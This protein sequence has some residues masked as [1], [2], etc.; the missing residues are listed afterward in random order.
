MFSV[1]NSFEVKFCRH[2]IPL[3]LI[4]PLAIFLLLELADEKKVNLFVMR[5]S[6]S[7]IPFVSPMQDFLKSAKYLKSGCYG[8]SVRKNLEVK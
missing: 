6:V 4:P 2:R 5:F 7:G 1:I 8:V 3:T